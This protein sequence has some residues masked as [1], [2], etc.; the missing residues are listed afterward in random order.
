MKCQMKIYYFEIFK[1]LASGAPLFLFILSFSVT[2]HNH[3]CCA[4]PGQIQKFW[5]DADPDLE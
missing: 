3:K 2:V 5:P 4:E 1:E